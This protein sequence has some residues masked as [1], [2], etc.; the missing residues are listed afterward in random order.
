MNDL[1]FSSSR[2][3]EPNG[4]FDFACT[5]CGE[6]C[7]G[8]INIRLNLNDL[9]KM[10]KYLGLHT[11][12]ELFD[13]AYVRLS[14]GEMGGFR[15]ILVFKNSLIRFCP[16]LENR[17]AE[18]GSFLGRCRL[19]PFHKPL[20]CKLAPLGRWVDVKGNDQWVFTEP[21]NGCPGCRENVR[22]SVASIRETHTLEIE[23]ESLYYHTL[24]EMVEAG[25]SFQHY[26]Q[27]HEQMKTQESVRGY[28]ERFIH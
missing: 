28:L 14:E 26:Q 4:T 25:A 13:G 1:E 11:T 22:C 17:L 5:S 18:D 3:L 21:V 8:E 15:P 10:A 27:L 20:V 2:P 23:L 9:Q 16:F 6:C 7:R 12:G 24:Q 19:H